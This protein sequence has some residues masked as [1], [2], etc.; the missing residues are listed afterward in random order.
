M[1]E[2]LEENRKLY[3]DTVK[4]VETMDKPTVTSIQ[5]AF[6]IG[7]GRAMNIIDE[8]HQRRDWPRCGYAVGGG[9]RTCFRDKGHKEAHAFE[10]G[11]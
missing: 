11:Q 1:S 5:R 3:T 6:R 9:G 2:L 10:C 8:M 7:Y 4:L